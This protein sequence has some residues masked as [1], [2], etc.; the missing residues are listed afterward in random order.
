MSK[1]EKSE[2]PNIDRE[3]QRAEA[4]KIYR[5]KKK[6]REGSHIEN[7]NP[8]RPVSQDNPPIEVPNL[9]RRKKKEQNVDANNEDGPV[10]ERE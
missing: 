4:D 2:N 7:K 1:E 9:D 10:S 8:D 5:D 3:K 6:F